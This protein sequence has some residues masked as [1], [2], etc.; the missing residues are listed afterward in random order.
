[1]DDKRM[2]GPHQ[3]RRIVRSGA[4]LEN[5]KAAV[6][7]VHGRGAT[8]ESILQL[9]DDLDQ[10]DVAYLAPQAGGNTWYP[11]SFLAPTERNEPGLSSG[12]K[13]IDDVLKKVEEV[14]IPRER[15]VVIGFS[16]GACLGLEYVA[17]NPRRYGGAVALSGGLIGTSSRE[18]AQPPNDKLFEYDGSLDGTPVFL[19][20]SDVDAHIP[21]ERI[22]Q[23]T[24]VLRQ[25]GGDVTERIY[26]GM[27]HTVNEDELAFVRSILAN[28]ASTT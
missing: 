26:E 18:G 4:S 20:G 8:A 2:T 3:G 27:G 17:R 21:I 11:N 19:G 12:L 23:S 28:L 14:G 24:H 25:L 22:H 5:A 10:P 15:I 9:A 16:Q 6:I 13:A 7:L 1:M